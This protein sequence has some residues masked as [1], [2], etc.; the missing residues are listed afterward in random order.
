MVL[1]WAVTR[2][3]ASST[4]DEKAMGARQAWMSRSGLRSKQ[5]K[6]T[7]FIP[8]VMLSVCQ[9]FGGGGSAEA[10]EGVRVATGA[11]AGERAA[12]R[13]AADAGG[14]ARRLGIIRARDDGNPD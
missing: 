10:L 5:Q 12:R 13:Q 6:S 11:S 3:T 1:E 4:E 2:G 14:P 8:N 7:A 9:D